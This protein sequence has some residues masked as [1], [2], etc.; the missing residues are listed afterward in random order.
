MGNQEACQCSRPSPWRVLS[1]S[2]VLRALHWHQGLDGL[3]SLLCQQS[4]VVCLPLEK[5]AGGEALPRRRRLEAPIHEALAGRAQ[6]GGGGLIK[7]STWFRSA[8]PA[9]IHNGGFSDSRPPLSKL[10][11]RRACAVA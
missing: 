3:V 4:G 10:A 1:Y 5:G 6:E 7:V 2:Q 9:H 8:F 11:S